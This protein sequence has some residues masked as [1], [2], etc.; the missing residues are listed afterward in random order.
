MN[1]TTDQAVINMLR[2]VA[3]KKELIEKAKKR[4]QW[5]TNCVFKGIAKNINIQTVRDENV[6]LE[7]LGSL[8][9][10]K[11][12]KEEAANILELEYDGQ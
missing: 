8:I 1:N 5:K 7:I 12:A 9:L 3:E 2:K 11:K 6:L 10:E 4:P